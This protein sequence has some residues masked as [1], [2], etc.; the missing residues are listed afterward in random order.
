MLSRHAAEFSAIGCKGEAVADGSKVDGIADIHQ[1]L[2]KTGE[3]LLRLPGV[4]RN[5][6]M[7]RHE[8]FS[9]ERL[10]RIERFKP[11]EAVTA[12][13]PKSVFIETGHTTRALPR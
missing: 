9:T 4:G 2:A 13:T 7:R 5:G 3:S 6:A 11:V 8:D 1:H 10:D 12:M